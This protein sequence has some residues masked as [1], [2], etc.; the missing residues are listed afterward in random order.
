MV[1]G[2][3]REALTRMEVVV[4]HAQLLVGPRY[5]GVL[6]VVGEVVNR[7]RGPG[8]LLFFLQ[9]VS[10]LARG[11]VKSRRI[12][13]AAHG[14]G[15]LAD[16]SSPAPSRCCGCR[17][18]VLVSV[19]TAPSNRNDGLDSAGYLRRL[20]PVRPDPEPH[21]RGSFE[22]VA[23]LRKT[24]GAR[25][26]TETGPAVSDRV[27]SHA[28]QLPDFL[29]RTVAFANSRLR[30]LEQTAWPID[31]I[32]VTRECGNADVPCLR[33][34]GAVHE[35]QCFWLEASSQAAEEGRSSGR[36]VRRPG[37][38]TAE[39]RESR[40]GNRAGVASAGCVG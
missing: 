14:Y 22:L 11:A 39:D 25:D 31:Q 37:V 5:P 9:S 19:G 40:T 8:R 3:D 29:F 34:V 18:H 21:D 24:G 2:I 1:A 36:V 13:V 16:T 12:A 7:R 32:P 26:M 28:R 17:R 20:S 15:A 4:C 30:I 6:Q 38:K 33:Q 35:R 27:P 10:R 23:V